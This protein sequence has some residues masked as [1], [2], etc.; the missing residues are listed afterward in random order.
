MDIWVY[1]SYICGMI[2]VLEIFVLWK[3]LLSQNP[4]Q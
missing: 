2:S 1:F 4:M 3:Y